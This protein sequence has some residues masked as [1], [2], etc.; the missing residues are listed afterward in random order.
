MKTEPVREHLPDRLREAGRAAEPDFRAARMA[1][2]I[3]VLPVAAIEQHGPHLPVG[4]DVAIQQGYLDRV[5]DRLPADLQVL[6]LPI[7]A[8]GVSTEHGD[9]PG[10]LSLSL[11]P[12]WGI[13][14]IRIAAGYNPQGLWDGFVGTMDPG[15]A[16][17]VDIAVVIIMALAYLVIAFNLFRVVDHRA[18]IDGNLGRI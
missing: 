8:V 4:V 3:A 18:R 14:A 6:F 16:F 13:D 9:F 17:M 7:Q 15:S 2:V 5:A 11:A 12:S 1:E 10:T